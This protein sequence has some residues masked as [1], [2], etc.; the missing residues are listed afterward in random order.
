M[1]MGYGKEIR[2]NQTNMKEA[3]QMI[4]NVVMVFLLGLVEMY[5]KET[6]LTM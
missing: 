6:I 2:V 1:E 4:K 3:M 5:I